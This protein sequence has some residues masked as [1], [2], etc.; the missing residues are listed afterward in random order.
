MK[1]INDTLKELNELN[2]D[3]INKAYPIIADMVNSVDES[4]SE[5]KFSEEQIKDICAVTGFITKL[6]A[7]HNIELPFDMSVNMA[8]C[9]II[10]KEFDEAN[11]NLKDFKTYL[12]TVFDLQMSYFDIDEEV[13]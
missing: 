10:L 11:N 1:T 6:M 12:K 8:S 9:I 2:T 3:A 7:K 4:I 5:Q 13:A